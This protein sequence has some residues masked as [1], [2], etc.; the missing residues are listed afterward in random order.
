MINP[1]TK[2]SEHFTLRELCKSDKH[3]EIYNVPPF[4]AVDN[5]TFVCQWLEKLREAYNARYTSPDL[6]KG[7]EGLRA[8]ESG[9]HTLP[10]EGK[11]E[12]PLKINSGYRSRQLNHAVG[13][14]P[15]SNHLTG[16][17]VDIRCEGKDATERGIRAFRYATLLME[18]LLK[19]HKGWEEIIVERNGTSWWV[20]FA[21]AKDSKRRWLTVINKTK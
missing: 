5:L 19:E 17:A 15:T 21:I 16:K 3:P 12:V 18:I 11:G 13:G 2:L 20:H 6:P 10:L 14:M 8:S 1:E 4:E 9:R 7:E